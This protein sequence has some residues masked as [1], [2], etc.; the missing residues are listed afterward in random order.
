MV[1]GIVTWL[2][3]PL[4][5]ALIAVVCG[6]LAR[7]EIRRAP[8]PGMEGDGMAVAGL[9]LGYLHLAVVAIVMFFFWGFVLLGLGAAW[10]WH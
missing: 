5:G 7:A 1:F 10:H 2:V 4:V 9:V 8:A 3:L 6:H